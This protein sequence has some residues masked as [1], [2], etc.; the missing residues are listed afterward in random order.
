MSLLDE[1]TW[2]EEG[3]PRSTARRFRS[4]MWDEVVEA[5]RA[6]PGKWLIFKDKGRNEPYRLRT[7]YEGLVVEAHNTRVNE[8]GKKRCDIWLRWPVADD[9]KPD[10]DSE[11]GESAA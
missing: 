2:S 6:R 1:G 11:D 3:P 9:G 7:R 4:S 8:D 10:G 5:L